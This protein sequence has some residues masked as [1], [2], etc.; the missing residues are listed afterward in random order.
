MQ[1]CSVF[2]ALCRIEARQLQISLPILTKKTEKS[3][4]FVQLLQTQRGFFYILTVKKYKNY[5][6]KRFVLLYNE[7]VEYLLTLFG[8]A[9]NLIN[10]YSQTLIYTTRKKEEQPYGYY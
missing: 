1:T 7:F 8:I 9:P 10:C 3:S 4:F 5:L 2:Q 6:E